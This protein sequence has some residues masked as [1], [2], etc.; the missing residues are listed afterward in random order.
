MADKNIIIRPIM[1]EK[2]DGLV[3][4]G[5]YTFVVE[6]TVNKIEVGKAIKA[7]YGVQPVSVNTMVMPA[8]AK[9]RNT[10][11]GVIRGRVSAYKKAIVTL[12]EGDTIDIYGAS[13]E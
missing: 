8:K 7:L 3:T 11:A 5:R 12:A 6:R 9:N 1:T 2:S 13:N 10:R 4:K